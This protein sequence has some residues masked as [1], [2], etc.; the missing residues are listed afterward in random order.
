MNNT[1][2]LLLVGAGVALAWTMRP[3]AT[4]INAQNSRAV[5][6]QQKYAR[7]EGLTYAEYQELTAGQ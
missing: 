5:M 2:L 6:L 3:K 7:G 1:L 4:I